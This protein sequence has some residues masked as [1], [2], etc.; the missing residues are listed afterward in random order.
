MNSYRAALETA[1]RLA[2]RYLESLDQRPVVAPA[3]HCTLRERLGRPLAN[4]GLAPL[5]GFNEIP[6]PPIAI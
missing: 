1:A 3:G 4:D 5:F 6:M 2:L